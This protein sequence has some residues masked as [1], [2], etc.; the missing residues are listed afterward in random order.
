MKSSL[1]VNPDIPV[2]SCFLAVPH[3]TCAEVCHYVN[4]CLN[5]DLPLVIHPPAYLEAVLWWLR[6]SFPHMDLHAGGEDAQTGARR[7]IGRRHVS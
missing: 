7:N 2:Q 1:P 6:P 3:Y 5:E 4:I